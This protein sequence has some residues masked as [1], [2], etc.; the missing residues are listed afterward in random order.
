MSTKALSN[1]YASVTHREL[2]ELRGADREA[3]ITHCTNNLKNV[4]TLVRRDTR[5][6]TQAVADSTHRGLQEIRDAFAQLSA[7]TSMFQ[8]ALTNV[9]IQVKILSR[10]LADIEERTWRARFRRWANGL[11]SALTRVFESDELGQ[12]EDEL[13]SEDQIDALSRIHQEH[14]Q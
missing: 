10:Q 6:M 11:V 7:E 8:L 3:I 4:E 5:G 14:S 9:E 2:T 1:P 12:Y 13:V